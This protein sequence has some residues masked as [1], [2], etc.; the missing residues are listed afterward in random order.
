MIKD[1]RLYSVL[2]A[3]RWGKLLY[4][5]SIHFKKCV[6]CGIIYESFI[7]DPLSHRLIW[8]NNAMGRN[9]SAGEYNILCAREIALGHAP[10]IILDDPS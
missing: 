1:N 2:G 10:P 6:I 3:L 8:D 7:A 9:P 4:N 5:G